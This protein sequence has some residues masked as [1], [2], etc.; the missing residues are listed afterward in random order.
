MPT[1]RAPTR[2][3]AQS[4]HQLVCLQRVLATVASRA[5][6]RYSPLA[7][8]HSPPNQPTSDQPTLNIGHQIL[9]T[10]H[11]TPESPPNTKLQTPDTRIRYRLDYYIISF[12]SQQEADPCP[13]CLAPLL[14]EIWTLPSC[15]HRFHLPCL[16]QQYNSLANRICPESGARLQ[17]RCG[18]CRRPYHKRDLP[19]APEVD[20]YAIRIDPAPV[21]VP[22]ISQMPVRQRPVRMAR[23]IRGLLRGR[24][25]AL[26]NILVARRKAILSAQAN[27]RGEQN[28]EQARQPEPPRSISPQ[29]GPSGLCNSGRSAPPPT[30]TPDSPIRSS[31]GPARKREPVFCSSSESESSQELRGQQLSTFSHSSRASSSPLHT[32]P[33]RS[34]PP[35]DMAGIYGR[36]F[37]GYDIGG[38]RLLHGPEELQDVQRQ[39]STLQDQQEQLEN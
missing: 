3:L 25:D 12:M 39:I 1:K 34:S 37:H 30:E 28:E 35:L 18:F 32:A 24:I 29:P 8:N 20:R 4:A 14:Q 17:V 15:G 11:R 27:A 21:D 38:A 16:L 23:M 19:K 9:D 6:L 22:A 26:L 13:I 7:P 10:G 36:G 5:T 33:E 2:A 31:G